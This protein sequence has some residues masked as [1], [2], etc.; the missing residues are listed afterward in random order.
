MPIHARCTE[1]GAE[2]NLADEQEGKKVRCKKC[3]EV[4]VVRPARAPK[5]REITEK[6]PER[7]AVRKRPAAAAPKRAR[8]EADES[9][10][11]QRS[12]GSSNNVP[13]L[14]GGGLAALLIV[15]GGVI[16]VLA[17][18]KADPTEPEQQ[19][20]KEPPPPQF[21]RNPPVFPPPVIPP[22]GNKDAPPK[23]E[24]PKV[25]PPKVEPPKTEPPPTRPPTTP[26]P[27]SGEL[28]RE[29]LDRVKRG[30][31]LL[32]VTE[33]DGQRSNGSGFFGVA[34]GIVLTNAHVL[35]MLQPESTRPRKLEVVINSG[36]PDEKVVGARILGVDR[37]SDLA[38][39][40]IGT[41]E[42]M[43]Q[44]LS[45]SGASH[46]FETQK[47]FVIGFPLGETL[48]REVSVRQSSVAALRKERNNSK[49]LKR[50]QLNGGMD[51]GNSGGPVVDSNGNVVGVSVAGIVGTQIVFAI[52]GER[53]HTIL[54]GRITAMSIGQPFYQSSSVA[55]PV[56]MKMLD[57]RRG[58]KETALD[59]WVGNAG[60]PRD[61]AVGKAPPA[62]PGDTP[63]QSIKLAYLAGEAKGDVMLPTLPSGKVYWVQPNWVN[64]AGEKHYATASVYRLASPPV[65][66]EPHRLAMARPRAGISRA[67]SL[68]STSTF[69]IR[70]ED[71][72]FSIRGNLETQMTEKVSRVTS[73][74]EVITIS[75][76]RVALGLSRSDKKPV[77]RSAG[78][79]QAVNSLGRLTGA[80]LRSPQGKLQH[81][82]PD[83]RRVSPS[84]RE[85]VK[86]LHEQIQHSLSALSVPLPNRT[87][88]VGETWK[89][90]RSMPIDTPGKYSLG[91][92]DMSYTYLG[93]RKSGNR[94]HAVLAM[95][96]KVRNVPGLSIYSGNAS[97]SLVV[98][99]F[100][101]QVV[102]ASASISVDTKADFFGDTVNLISI[103]DVKLTRSP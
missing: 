74:G 47:V 63:R 103:L 55:I 7:S 16:A 81:Y 51:P 54:N 14:V 59:V 65:N 38:V 94:R 90:T 19:A 42:G 29:V 93:W 77:P 24:P 37:S 3:S 6:K 60:N 21:P 27:R 86:A 9:P 2:Y 66:R 53:V 35:G 34:P 33:G 39:L 69:K 32:R 49:V 79:Q 68:K 101:G 17:M 62:M 56:T 15:V 84:V 57:P 70:T 36:Q 40:D 48:G 61:P 67:V 22:A 43:P 44:P 18:N 5:S 45:V 80:V 72:S 102:A 50:V 8:A 91:K 98:D 64:T 52:P 85:E 89:A 10:T 88:N 78:I 25:E 13:W 23:I 87:V 97:G 95:Q 31:V 1:C 83:L 46:L 73:Q 30:T 12:G 82:P 96:G 100:S 20:R 92:I 76:N 75:Y 11:P 26:P 41:G 71:E 28:T 99:T 4:F 58:I